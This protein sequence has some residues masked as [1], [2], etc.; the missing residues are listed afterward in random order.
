MRIPARCRCGARVTMSI[1]ESA[2]NTE[3]VVEEC[4]KC[5]PTPVSDYRRD[6]F[7]AKHNQLERAFWDQGSGQETNQ[8]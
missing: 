3:R 7:R 8:D 4:D 5:T 2:W 1:A 6:C